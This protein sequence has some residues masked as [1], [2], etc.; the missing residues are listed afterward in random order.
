MMEFYGDNVRWWIG[1]VVNVLD[2]LQLG[3]CIDA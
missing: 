3:H 1:I 2:P